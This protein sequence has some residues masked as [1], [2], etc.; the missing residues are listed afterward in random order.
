MKKVSSLERSVQRAQAQLWSFVSP[1]QARALAIG[2]DLQ[3]SDRMFYIERV[4]ALA[5]NI[6]YLPRES[7]VVVDAVTPI[8]LHYSKDGCHWYVASLDPLRLN[9][10]LVYGH[11]VPARGRARSERFSLF[12]II[13]TGASL[14]IDWEPCELAEAHLRRVDPTLARVPKPWA[15][16]TD[17]GKVIDEFAD[18]VPAYKLREACGLDA[19]VLYRLYDG[20]LVT[21]NPYTHGRHAYKTLLAAAS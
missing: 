16:V 7:L 11:V 5:Y 9:R 1:A 2:L 15:V 8:Y 4:V 17:E 19:D 3:S 18:F 21:P 6:G 20:R 13:S 10:D 14:D 12:D